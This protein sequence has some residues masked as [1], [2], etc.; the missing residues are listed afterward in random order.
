VIAGDFFLVATDFT[1]GFLIGIVAFFSNFFGVAIVVNFFLSL[2]S[3]EMAKKEL[4]LKGFLEEAAK[5]LVIFFFNSSVIFFYYIAA[6]LFKAAV[7]FALA[8]SSSYILSYS[9]FFYSSTTY[10]YSSLVYAILS[11]FLI[12]SVNEPKPS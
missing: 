12:I 9:F 3:V 7:I 5:V 8:F 4:S 11:L 10:Y 6:S 2:L 1:A